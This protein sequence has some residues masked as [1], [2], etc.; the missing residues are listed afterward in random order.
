MLFIAD[1]AIAQDVVAK[2]DNSTTQSTTTTANYNSSR[3]SFAAQLN[4]GL[5][6]RGEFSYKPSLQIGSYLTDHLSWLIGVGYNMTS[7]EIKTYSASGKPTTQTL[8]TNTL[9][10][11]LSLNLTL[12]DKDKFW[13]MKIQGGVNYNYILSMELGSDKMDLD[14]TDRSGFSGHI[15]CVLFSLLFGEYNFPFG[16]GKGAFTF[17]LCF[18]I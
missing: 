4:F 18:G 14:G 17:G 10:F 12:G 8:Y 9:T 11:P 7:S 1:I 3:N 6:E 13:N 2:K 15:R 16:D 5:F